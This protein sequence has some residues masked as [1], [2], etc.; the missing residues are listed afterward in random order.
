MVNNE[1]ELNQRILDL[2]RELRLG[3][4]VLNLLE[5]G[6]EF[7]SAKQFVC[8]LLEGV[9]AKR[10][11][12]AIRKN[13]KLAGF[14]KEHS[15]DTFEFNPDIYFPDRFPKEWFIGC[16]FVREKQNVMLLGNSGTGKTH[17]ATALGR[18]ACEM[19]YRVMYRKTS[20]FIDELTTAYEKGQFKRYREKVS[21]LDLLVLDEWGYLP[22]S[23]NSTKLLYDILSDCYENRSIM[24]TTNLPLKEWN[25]IFS[26]E[27][28][29]NALLDRL[30]H[31]GLLIAHKGE[32]YRRKNAL[33]R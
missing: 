21:K 11:Q 29:I 28:L 15:L 22:V 9:K 16:D 6:L 4:H 27:R 26:D 1:S 13:L 25:R 33:M 23:T 14:E 31:H 18:R 5:D 17:L 19:G 30:V 10:N 32:S 8:G 7:T 2:S 24:L 20:L 3:S 12:E